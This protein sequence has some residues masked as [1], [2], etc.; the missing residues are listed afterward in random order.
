MAPQQLSRDGLDHV[1]EIESALLLRHAGVK[2]HL[3]QQVAQLLAQVDKVAARDRISD[4]VGFLER[5]G[6]NGLERLFEVPR[7]PGSGGPQGCHDLNQSGDVAGRFHG[8]GRDRIRTMRRTR[9]A[10]AASTRKG[11][12]C[13]VRSAARLASNR[14]QVRFSAL[15]MNIS[16]RLAVATSSCSSASLWA[17]RIWAT[18]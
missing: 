3:Q 10:S 4:L 8:P 9:P 17:S 7:A 16:S 6:G 11:A 1:A 13:P 18:T 15:S 2:D 14:N 12:Q 5:V